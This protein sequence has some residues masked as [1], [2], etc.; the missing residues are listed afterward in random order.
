MNSDEQGKEVSGQ[1]HACAPWLCP[2]HSCGTH[3]HHPCTVQAASHCAQ[4]QA[5]WGSRKHQD[6]AVWRRQPRALRLGKSLSR[7]RTARL[8]SPAKDKHS[9]IQNHATNS[10]LS[11][12]CLF[13][14][15]TMLG[16][17]RVR[18]WHRTVGSCLSISPLALG[19]L[20]P[21]SRGGHDPSIT[22]LGS[23]RPSAHKVS[24]VT[25]HG[26]SRAGSIP[27]EVDK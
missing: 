14:G 11:E 18:G 17:G 13:P 1:G 21:L 7:T 10:N 2:L 20:V 19:P 27:P 22:A 5:C 16:M 23:L 8:L 25:G 24:L 9:E 26:G 3:R 6:Q 12:T 15:A 4:H